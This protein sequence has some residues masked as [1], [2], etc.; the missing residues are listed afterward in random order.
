MRAAHALDRP[1]MLPPRAVRVWPPLEEKE[2]RRTRGWPVRA[3]RPAA[4][5]QLAAPPPG[6]PARVTTAPFGRATAGLA[7]LA[8]GVRGA[9][10]HRRKR[11][12]SV[13][14]RVERKG[15]DGV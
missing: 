15:D 3:P 6:R 13:A 4:T 7:P 5:P 8:R 14:V 12:W 9:R 1:G 2:M 10:D 11:H